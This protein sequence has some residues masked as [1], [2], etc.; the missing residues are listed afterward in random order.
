M[1]QYPAYE[2]EKVPIPDLVNMLHEQLSMLGREQKFH[3]KENSE[4]SKLLSF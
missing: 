3:L 4:V 1:H 2:M